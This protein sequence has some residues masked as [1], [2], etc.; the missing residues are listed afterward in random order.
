MQSKTFNLVIAGVGGQGLITLLQVL[1]QA[2]MDKG[3]E[4]RTSELHGLSQRGGS[5]SVHIRLGEKVYSP[6]IPKRQANLVIAL[7]MQEALNA[8]PFASG[9]TTFLINKYQSPTMGQGVSESYI[10]SAI[11]GI[12]KKS[13][14]LS[15][16]E[17]TEK[18]LGN[19]VVSGSFFLGYA[20][21]K[22]L[23]P[24]TEND[25]KEAI[26]KVMPEKH[27]DINMKTIDFAKQYHEK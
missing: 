16:N 12:T 4:V 5:V 22:G 18:E 14:F 24:F 21:T 9:R 11:T 27:W 10:K 23:I 15:A 1:A 8:V 19:S 25:I 17:I 26:K 6:M 20:I 2:A 13:V 7:E 3:L